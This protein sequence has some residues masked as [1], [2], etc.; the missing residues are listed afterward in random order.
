MLDSFLL[1]SETF[2]GACRG[3]LHAI[4]LIPGFQYNT[5]VQETLSTTRAK[6]RQ[7]M[8]SWHRNQLQHQ[9]VHPFPSPPPLFFFE[10][11]SWVLK[12]IS[13]Q[14]S[15]SDMGI[16]VGR[17][18]NE[19]CWGLQIV[20]TPDCKEVPLKGVRIPANLLTLYNNK[21]TGQQSKHM[22][23]NVVYMVPQPSRSISAGCRRSPLCC[24]HLRQI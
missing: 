14:R 9:K 19:K 10:Q 17:R 11:G 21:R 23:A 13:L 15:V 22:G 16:R 2:S 20:T 6:H 4:F 7:M 12:T 24:S 8:L 18:P 5:S 3:P 1:T